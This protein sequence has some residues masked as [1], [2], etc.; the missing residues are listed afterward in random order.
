[1]FCPIP[2]NRCQE[3]LPFDVSYCF[4][5]HVCITKG[6]KSQ[7]LLFS[8]LVLH[9]QVH[10]LWSNALP[11]TFWC[12]QFNALKDQWA[13]SHMAC[14]LFHL[15][16][17]Q[18]QLRKI[19]DTLETSQIQHVSNDSHLSFFPIILMYCKLV[20]C[21]MGIN[22]ICQTTEVRNRIVTSKCI[23]AWSSSYKN[24]SHSRRC[25]LCA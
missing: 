9:C 16:S 2:L 18:K 3:F 23:F 22:W 4:E 24:W 11:A 1:M 5:P 21:Q 6:S 12:P 20:A 14:S 13:E 25:T 8:R 17:E 19:L 7:Y 15:V 10:L